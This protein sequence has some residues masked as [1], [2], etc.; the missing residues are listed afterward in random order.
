MSPSAMSCSTRALF[1]AAQALRA[2]RGA[3]YS[4][5]RS[6]STRPPVLSTQPK[7]SASSTAAS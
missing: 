4:L 2:L 6:S 3:K 5:P 1:V 7:H